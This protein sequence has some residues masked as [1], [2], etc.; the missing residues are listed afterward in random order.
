M[1]HTPQEL[2]QFSSRR[3]RCSISHI[4]GLRNG[5]ADAASRND[6]HGLYLP[7]A[8]LNVRPVKMETPAKTERTEREV[9]TVLQVM[10]KKKKMKK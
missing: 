1:R 7:C 2:L 6:L 9:K 5:A 3:D 4:Y 10:K 8:S